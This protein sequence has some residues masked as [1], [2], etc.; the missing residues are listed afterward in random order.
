M[1]KTRKTFRSH[2]D[3]RQQHMLS[4]K[5]MSN[6]SEW[7]GWVIHS[8]KAEMLFGSV[9][10]VN[11]IYMGIEADIRSDDTFQIEWYLVECV[12][13]TIF[14][15]ELLMR[16]VAEK[17][18]FFCIAWNLFDAFLVGIS[19]LDLCVVTPTKLQS[20]DE[21]D[22]NVAILNII[23]VTRLV[24]LARILRILR[25]LRFLRELL[26]LV[27]SI[28]GA[29][30]TLIWVSLLLLVVLFITAIIVTKLIQRVDHLEHNEKAQ[31]YFGS[32]IE[33]MF[34]LFQLVTV[35]AWNDVARDMMDDDAIGFWVAILFVLFLCLTN[36][37][38]LNLMSGVIFDNV[39][40]ISK[41]DQSDHTIEAMERERIDCVCRL[42]EAFEAAD[43]NHDG[44]L[45][46]TE[47][48][49]SLEKNEQVMDELGKLGLGLWDAKEVFT[50]LD[51]DRSGSLT[52]EE[53]M[54]GCLRARGSATAKHML[55]LQAATHHMWF[56]IH[57]QCSTS[58]KALVDLEE[59]LAKME[60]FVLS[61]H[62]I[63]KVIEQQ[64]SRIECFLLHKVNGD[65]LV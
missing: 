34:T 61:Q 29:V 64:L 24:R 43:I 62:A 14:L 6:T 63:S 19:F 3:E 28:V 37:T 32:L 40:K 45:T 20:G 59:R 26:L 15:I 48:R 31:M 42:R 38:L 58:L 51:F 23:R 35:E 9:I 8:P 7:D 60:N 41:E 1:E 57:V 13:F 33:S 4:K 12:F 47:L 30:K 36:L 52:A 10:V 22:T 54:E 17:C 55:G 5:I 25:L 50:L 11:S 46:L 27:K 21:K 18:R 44:L 39:L 16:L 56:N 49:D 53:F 65:F 2:F